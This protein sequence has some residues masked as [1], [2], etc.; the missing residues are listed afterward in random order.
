M[1]D[2]LLNLAAQALGSRAL[3][4]KT[5]FSDALILEAAES[6]GASI[7]YSEG[8]GSR[9]LYGTVQVVNPLVDATSP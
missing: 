4:Y 9:Q 5:S 2:C 1:P 6:S 8:L 3:R 7:L